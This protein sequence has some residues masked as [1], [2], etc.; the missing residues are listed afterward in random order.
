MVIAK[1]IDGVEA[2]AVAPG[3]FRRAATRL[4]ASIRDIARVVMALLWQCGVRRPRWRGRRETPAAWAPSKSG[5]LNP[6]S[7]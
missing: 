3:E 2:S 5:K 4:T 1:H 7:K 6:A